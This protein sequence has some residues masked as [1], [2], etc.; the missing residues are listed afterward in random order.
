M[1]LV[2]FTL[3]FYNFPALSMWYWNSSTLIVIHVY[4]TKIAISQKNIRRLLKRFGWYF[5]K[6]TVFYFCQN[7][8]KMCRLLTV[9]LSTNI[10]SYIFNSKN[11]RNLH[12]NSTFLDTLPFS[13]RPLFFLD[14]FHV[15]LHCRSSK[16]GTSILWFALNDNFAYKK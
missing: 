5:S 9:L 8:M 6:R 4:V 12:R 15:M 11:E 3:H 1:C 7:A 2:L 10:T 14:L 13:K 16:T